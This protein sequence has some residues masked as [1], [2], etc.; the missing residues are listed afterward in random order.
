[1]GMSLLVDIGGRNYSYRLDGSEL[2][3]L[4]ELCSTDKELGPAVE[5]VLGGSN[6]AIGVPRC[7]KQS[8]LLKAVSKLARLDPGLLRSEIYSVLIDVLP[9]RFAPSKASGISGIRIDGNLYK[10]DAGVDRCTLSQVHI[11]DQGL[12]ETVSVQDIRHL[13]KIATDNQG[14]IGIVKTAKAAR[15]L[16]TF[17]TLQRVLSEVVGDPDVSV[18]IG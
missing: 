8:D 15:L 10:I 17:K 4:Q 14:E 3:V 16:R 1:M 7:V 12:G 6:D 13:R 11:N 2:E 9:G 5:M 18:T